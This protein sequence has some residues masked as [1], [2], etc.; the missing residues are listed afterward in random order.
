MIWL[1]WWEPNPSE[2]KWHGCHSKNWYHVICY[3]I[4][5][6]LIKYGAL[7]Y[8]WDPKNRR[9]RKVDSNFI[10]NK[11]WRT[12]LLNGHINPKYSN[13]YKYLDPLVLRVN[14]PI[15]K[16][17]SRNQVWSARWHIFVHIYVT[18]R[19]RSWFRDVR[20]RG[21]F[22]KRCCLALSYL[23]VLKRFP[24]ESKNR[25]FRCLFSKTSDVL[26]NEEFWCQL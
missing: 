19:S 6:K 25:N 2:E 14:P 8:L 13:I 24:N 15:F 3:C 21:G 9:T 4:C 5:V 1:F 20:L 12:L 17:I 26:F 7:T 22:E 16:W 23:Y 11:P 10:K 18:E